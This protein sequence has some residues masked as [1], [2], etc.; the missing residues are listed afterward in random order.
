MGS[1]IGEVLEEYRSSKQGILSSCQTYM[2]CGQSLIY[3]Y[4]KSE[5]LKRIPHKLQLVI[6]LLGEVDTDIDTVVFLLDDEDK[7]KND[8][9]T[10]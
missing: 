9:G 4:V 1:N 8:T 7:H 3:D 5:G 2:R 6:D 10:K